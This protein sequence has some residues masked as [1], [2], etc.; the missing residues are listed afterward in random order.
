M[1]VTTTKFGRCSR[2]V[3]HY[4]MMSYSDIKGADADS[5]LQRQF[6]NGLRDQSLQ[7]H[8]GLHVITDSFLTTVEKAKQL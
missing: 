7:K 1:T 4:R 8:S 2:D 3:L 6:V 5:A